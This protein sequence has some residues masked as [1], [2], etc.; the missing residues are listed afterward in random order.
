MPRPPI[1]FP[2]AELT[3]KD[4]D[5]APRR[6]SGDRRPRSSSC[7]TIGTGPIVSCATSPCAWRHF[8]R[9]GSGPSTTARP[10]TS[11][12]CSRTTSS[13]CRFSAAA[14]TPGSRSSASTPG[15]RGETLAG[16]INQSRARLLIV[17][18]RLLPEV[19]RVRA[20]L[21]HVAPENILVLPTAGGKIDRGGESHALACDGEVGRAGRDTLEPPA[22]RSTQTAT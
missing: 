6:A 18:E 16:V 22:S 13:C 7:R 19:E 1:Q 21:T 10:A 14:P 15:L 2:Q 17:D 9:G 11:R 3:P 20:Q 8:L 4:S 12:C 5:G